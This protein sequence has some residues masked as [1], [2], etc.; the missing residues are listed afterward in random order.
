MMEG[1]GRWGGGGMEGGERVGRDGGLTQVMLHRITVNFPESHSC[2]KFLLLK[3]LGQG[4]Q[5]I[6]PQVGD[7]HSRLITV[8]NL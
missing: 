4:S 7:Q 1:G 2:G 5:N 3:I 6:E 8:R